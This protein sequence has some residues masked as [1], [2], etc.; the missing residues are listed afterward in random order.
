MTN[1]FGQG[2]G[3]AWPWDISARLPE[4]VDYVA[5]FPLRVL[6]AN[7]FRRHLGTPDAPVCVLHQSYGDPNLDVSARPRVG[8]WISILS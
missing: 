6:D 2:D 8:D 5:V 7:L 1:G 4:E 3:F